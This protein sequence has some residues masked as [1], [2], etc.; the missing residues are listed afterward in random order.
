MATVKNKILFTYKD[1]KNWEPDLLIEVLS[2]TSEKRDKEI[3]FNR[4]AYFGMKAYWIVDPKQQSIETCDLTNLQLVA[5]IPV[6]QVLNSRC[7]P[8]LTW[9]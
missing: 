7:S 3:K 1:L 8:I 5:V 6:N 4:Y 9:S 2:A